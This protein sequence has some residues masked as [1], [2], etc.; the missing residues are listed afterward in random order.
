MK[1]S[2]N[3]LVGEVEICNNRLHRQVENILNMNRLE[4]GMLQ[5]RP[6]WCE[7]SEVVLC[8]CGSID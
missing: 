3:E 5:A 7:V 8:G 1:T 2:L 6:D 4:S